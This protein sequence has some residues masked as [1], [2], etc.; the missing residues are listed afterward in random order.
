LTKKKKKEEGLTNEV[1]SPRRGGAGDQRATVKGEK[2]LHT[3]VGGN[4]GRLIRK[5]AGGW[6]KGLGGGGGGACGGEGG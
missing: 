1:V 4:S 6:Q 2:G 3:Q 5:R